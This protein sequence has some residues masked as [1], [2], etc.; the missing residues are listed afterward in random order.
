MP[1]AEQADTLV[2]SFFFRI[3]KINVEKTSKIKSC[4]MKLRKVAE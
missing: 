1:F 4:G 2:T 3:Y